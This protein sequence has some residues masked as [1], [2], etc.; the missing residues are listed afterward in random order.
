[1]RNKEATNIYFYL[2]LCADKA[3]SWTVRGSIPG[4]DKIFFPPIP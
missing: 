4:T 1:M 3:T 2:S